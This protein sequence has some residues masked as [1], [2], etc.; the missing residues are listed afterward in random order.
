MIRSVALAV[1]VFSGVASAQTATTNEAEWLAQLSG[2]VSVEDF[3]SSTPTVFLGGV[4]NQFSGFTLTA[5]ND[6]ASFLTDGTGGNNIDGT[7]HLDLFV[8]PA[9]PDFG[10]ARESALLTFDEPTTAVAFDFADL[11]SSSGTQGV[12]F[13]IDGVL[14]GNTN[15]LGVGANGGVVA[16]TFIGIY[17]DTAFTTLEFASP[18]PAF[19]ETF[20]VD[21]LRIEVPA[22][23]AAALAGLAGVVAVRRRRI[24]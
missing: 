14:I 18:D 11:F 5:E 6:G 9:V 16:S 7:N 20:G 2:P 15:D 24:S 12:D 17:S 4:A 23:G 21:N 3:N 10:L 1:I 13:L 22:P 19:G 8:A